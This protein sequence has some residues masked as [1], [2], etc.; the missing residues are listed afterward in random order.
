MTIYFIRHG[1]TAGNLEKRYIGSTDLPLCQEGKALL[2]ERLYPEADTLYCS[3]M[4]RCLET[5]AMIYPDKKPIVIPD[6]RECDFGRYEGKNYA[7]LTEDAPY[8]RWVESGG[9]LPFPDGEDTDAFRARCTAAFAG[10]VKTHQAEDTLALVVHGGTI[11]S[12]LESYEPSHS[13][14]AWQ[15]K[16]GHGY[17]TSYENGILRETGEI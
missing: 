4:Q 6:F 9:V 7:E 8:L 16:N 5:A 10:V 1:M 3:P 12:I 11:M 14:F 17:C 15:C 13:Y 2:S